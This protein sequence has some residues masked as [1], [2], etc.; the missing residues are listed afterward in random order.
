MA[1]HDQHGTMRMPH[2]VFGCAA[3]QQVLEPSSSVSSRNDQVRV[4]I[5]RAR[6]DLLAGMT[7]LQ[8]GRHLNPIPICL[9]NQ[10]LHLFAGS[11]LGLLQEKRKI[12]AS[13]F[14]ASDIVLQSYRVEQDKLRTKLPG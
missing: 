2:N 7:N 13:I 12:V 14:V 10:L 8:R 9:S 4:M 6:A 11:F 1:R 5:Y 3:E